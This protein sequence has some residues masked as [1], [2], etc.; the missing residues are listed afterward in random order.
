MTVLHGLS[1]QRILKNDNRNDMA[2][3]TFFIRPV[4]RFHVLSTRFTEFP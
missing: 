2:R 4:A 3:I 1:H